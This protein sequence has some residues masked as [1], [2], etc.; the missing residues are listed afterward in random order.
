MIDIHTFNGLQALNSW[1]Y[2]TTV[3]LVFSYKNK[4]VERMD[5]H[6]IVALL[7]RAKFSSDNRL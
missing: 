7:E 1:V 2:G 6:K 4:V 3:V 5:Y